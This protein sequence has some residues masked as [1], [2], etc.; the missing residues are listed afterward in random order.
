VLTGDVVFESL[1]LALNF[2]RL[3]AGA[4]EERAVGLTLPAPSLTECDHVYW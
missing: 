4:G 1:S 3:S 2:S